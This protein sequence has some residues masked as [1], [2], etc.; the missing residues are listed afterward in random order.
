M[1]GI[2]RQ[3]LSREL[4]AILVMIAVLLG[5][6]LLV[7]PASKEDIFSRRYK[8][9]ACLYEHPSFNSTYRE[10]LF[11]SFALSENH[12]F[13]TQEADGSFHESGGMQEISLSKEELLA[14]FEP[15][16]LTADVRTQLTRTTAVWRA[17]GA[18]GQN[19]FFLFLRSRKTLLLA[20]GYGLGSDAPF[21]RWLF[22]LE[23]DTAA[24]TT[25]ELGALIRKSNN[26]NDWKNIQIYST[27]ESESLPGLLFAAY[28]GAKNGVA[29][30]SYDSAMPGY[31]I[32]M[33]TTSGSQDTFYS[34]TSTWYDLGKSY[35]IITSHHQNAAEVRSSWKGESLTAPITSCPA[36]VVLEWPDAFPCVPT[37]SLISA[38]TMRQATKFRANSTKNPLVFCIT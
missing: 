21:V 12:T 13:Y 25:Q 18:T 3:L 33:L 38:F 15:D 19:P 8:I 30:F 6:G 29:V 10:D 24:F 35:S 11:S 23:P 32:R 2:F 34:E 5:A 4:V 26:L 37:A 1:T 17:Q 7:N 27:Y 31:Y 16:W 20:V 9:S 36:M 28:D 22:A 14:L